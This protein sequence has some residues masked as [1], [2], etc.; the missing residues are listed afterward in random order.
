MTTLAIVAH[1]SRLDRAEALRREVGGELMVDINSVGH[2]ENHMRALKFLAYYVPPTQRHWG[3]VL[4]DDAEPVPGFRDEVREALKNAPTPVVS[5]Y[6]GR[7]R[8]AHWQA[9]ISSVIACSDY[10]LVA[11]ELLH[12][13]AYAIRGDKLSGLVNFLRDDT[14]LPIDES[15]SKWCAV[16]G[17]D[18]SYSHPSLVDHADIPSV[19]P[20]HQTGNQGRYESFP[21]DDRV[22]RR[23]WVVG[24]R[25]PDVWGKTWTWIPTPRPILEEAPS[26][27]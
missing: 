24:T 22:P 2:R 13:V 21:A 16:A 7:A 15:I 26:G 6:L 25:W 11:R 18:V 17:E 8:P 12:G 5:F 1:H 10:W 14:A 4:E 9:S 3:I 23:A 20:E 19:I 27:S